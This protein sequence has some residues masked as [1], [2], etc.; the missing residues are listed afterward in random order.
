MSSQTRYL[1][2]SSRATLTH[3]GVSYV[4]R[5]C[6]PCQ[7]SGH[8]L[9]VLPLSAADVTALRNAPWSVP[10]GGG[11]KTSILPSGEEI[12][13]S[14]NPACRWPGTSMAPRTDKK[15]DASAG[16]VPLDADASEEV[17]DAEED[18]ES[19]PPAAERRVG[20]LGQDEQRWIV[21]R[22]ADLLGA[23]EPRFARVT[24]RLIRDLLGR[25]TSDGMGPRGIEVEAL[26][27]SF[28]LL[29]HTTAA[30]AARET[31][32]FVH[33]HVV[34]CKVLRNWLLEERNRS[35]SED[36]IHAHLDRFCLAALIHDE[37][38]DLLPRSTMPEGWTLSLTSDPWARYKRVTV[39]D[40]RSLF[41]ALTFPEGYPKRPV[42]AAG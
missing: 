18:V 27:T 29:P 13:I 25:W 2:A 4:G 20:H 17:A 36:E 42:D 5:R 26:W 8:M 11:R 41:A 39:P 10:A 28:E 35:L 24:R 37:E 14:A 38:D 32:A 9:Y 12:F 15:K 6:Q 7:G 31:R 22:I 19:D 16:P 3:A 30:R 21:R 33:E 23:H 40:G 1:V 34:P